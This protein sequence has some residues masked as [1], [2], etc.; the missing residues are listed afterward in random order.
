[1]TKFDE[2]VTCYEKGDQKFYKLNAEVLTKLEEEVNEEALQKR[3]DDMHTILDRM[4]VEI[5]GPQVPYSQEV[6]WE[7]V[8]P[9]PKNIRRNND[10]HI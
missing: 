7:G 10:E 6:D 9:D 2:I 5:H 8:Y 3:L 4:Q 1:M